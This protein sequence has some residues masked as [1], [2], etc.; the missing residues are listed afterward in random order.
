MFMTSAWPLCNRLMQPSETTT[1]RVTTWDCG[2][3]PPAV[4]YIGRERA[5]RETSQEDKEDLMK[6]VCSDKMRQVV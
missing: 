2:W 1:T 6:L 3:G 5:K 4:V